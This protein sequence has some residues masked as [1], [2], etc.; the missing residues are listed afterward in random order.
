M[1]IVPIPL[2]AVSPGYSHQLL[3][4]VTAV[5][6]NI[7]G[8]IFGLPADLTVPTI[9]RMAVKLLNASAKM[10]I[11]YAGKLRKGSQFS[12]P[13][14][15]VELEGLF[16]KNEFQFKAWSNKMILLQVTA[17]KFYPGSTMKKRWLALPAK[18]PLNKIL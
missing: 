1:E 2:M 3:P 14:V 7:T 17:D 13:E 16:W 15:V 18:P 12:L 4:E 6:L 11:T 8:K 9:R 5:V 10:A